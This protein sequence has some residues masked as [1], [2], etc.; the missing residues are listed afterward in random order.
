VA[1][2]EAEYVT[3]A[4][5]IASSSQ[6]HFSGGGGGGGGGGGSSTRSLRIGRESASNKS[7]IARNTNSTT[8]NTNTNMAVRVR[9]AICAGKHRLFEVRRA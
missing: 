8:T 2:T 9:A 4:L 3:A 5:R 1:G 6:R 7:S